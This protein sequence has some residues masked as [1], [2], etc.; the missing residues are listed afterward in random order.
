MDH[1]P[2]LRKCLLPLSVLVV[3]DDIFN[4]VAPRSWWK[5]AECFVRPAW[6]GLGWLGVMNPAL[7]QRR[8]SGKWIGYLWAA[9]FAILNLQLGLMYQPGPG[10]HASRHR[11]KILALLSAY[12]SYH[13]TDFKAK[14]WE[15]NISDQFVGVSL[16]Y[17][18]LHVPCINVSCMYY[19]KCITF[20][21]IYHYK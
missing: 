3:C 19:R 15:E 16:L 14:T 10:E 7:A 21:S 17:L 5:L 6:P 13:Q 2:V 20:P 12:C 1:F 4:Q 8:M 18:P 11:I 9:F